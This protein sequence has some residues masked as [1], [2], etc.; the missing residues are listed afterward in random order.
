[1]MS[2]IWGRYTL[3]V[4]TALASLASVVLGLVLHSF[5]WLIALVAT[6]LFFL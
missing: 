1:M 3:W 6:A 5:F 4:A 2:V